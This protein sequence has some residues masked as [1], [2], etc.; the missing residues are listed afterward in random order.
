MGDT[1]FH[2][3]YT[4]N[5]SCDV[6]LILEVFMMYT[7]R[8][9]DGAKYTIYDSKPTTGYTITTKNVLT[10]EKEMCFYIIAAFSDKNI[11]SYRWIGL[12][13]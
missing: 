1:S 2:R 7:I 13:D 8:F 10:C 9:D 3:D 11:P 6:K 4:N 5:F 12:Q